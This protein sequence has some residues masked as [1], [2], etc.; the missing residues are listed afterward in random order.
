MENVDAAIARYQRNY[1][2]ALAQSRASASRGDLEW[3]RI[4]AQTDA[5]F[6]SG[7]LKPSPEYCSGG[8]YMPVHMRAF[9]AKH[10]ELRLREE[11]EQAEGLSE[12]GRKQRHPA[13]VAAAAQRASPWGK[14]PQATPPVADPLGDPHR[15]PRG[16]VVSVRDVRMD[17]SKTAEDLTAALRQQRR[18]LEN[19]EYRER[20]LY[21][22]VWLDQWNKFN[23]D[24]RA[25]VRASALENSG[26]TYELGSTRSGRPTSARSNDR[27]AGAPPSHIA[28]PPVP[29]NFGEG[30]MSGSGGTRKLRGVTPGRPGSAKASSSEPVTPR[31]Q[32][33]DER[34]PAEQ[35]SPEASAANAS[36]SLASTSFGRRWMKES[37]PGSSLPPIHKR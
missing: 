25:I 24:F 30:S 27:F 33:Q 32:G 6:H 16:S 5:D 23:R 22:G 31:Q 15:T 11:Q 7:K 3:L 21:S 18:D 35:A 26:S 20:L 37:R 8:S 10:A 19:A 34:V 36:T 17:S 12:S 2:V 14:P 28:P 29:A 1:P 13:T 4:V 9:F